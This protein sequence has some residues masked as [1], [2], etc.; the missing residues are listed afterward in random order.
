MESYG[1]DFGGTTTESFEAASVDAQLPAV[2][3]A[4][5]ERKLDNDDRGTAP[6][7]AGLFNQL[8]F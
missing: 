5:D 7:Q 6:A 8:D 2:D 3:S 1:S 4:V